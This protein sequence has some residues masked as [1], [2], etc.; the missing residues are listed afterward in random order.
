M[1]VRPL[2]S[3]AA[4]STPFKSA[5]GILS[6]AGC[7]TNCIKRAFGVLAFYPI[8]AGNTCGLELSPRRWPPGRHANP[9]RR[10]GLAV[11]LSK[12]RIKAFKAPPCH[13][14]IAAARSL[15]CGDGCINR[16]PIIGK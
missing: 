10:L 16:S 9:P 3:S 2:A 5:G 12:N 6:P 8:L 7:A 11:A 14:Q 15:L 13:P 1:P 4:R